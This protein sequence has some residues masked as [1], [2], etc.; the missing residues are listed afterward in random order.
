MQFD[1]QLTNPRPA[2]MIVTSGSFG[3]WVVEDPGETPVAGG[4]R[5]DNADLGVFKGIAGILNRPASTRACCATWRWTGRRNTPDFRLTHFGTAMPLET[6]FHATVD[7]TNGDT[8][9]HPVRAT[10]GSRTLLPKE[11]SLAYPAANSAQRNH[12]ARRAR[13]CAERK[14]RP[15]TNGGLFAPGEQERDAD[16]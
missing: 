2:G 9:L 4:Y 16:C 13:D 15:A 12:A 5:F 11:R 3:P 8:W 14:Y 6:R 10:L 1:A 7:G